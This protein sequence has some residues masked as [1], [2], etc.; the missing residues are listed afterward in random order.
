VNN[1][2][3]ED[4]CT[5]V[6]GSQP[7]KSEFCYE[8]KEGY[9]RLIQ[10]RDYKT[11]RFI[12]YIPTEKAKKFC[13][14]NDVMIGRYGPPVF[15]VLRGLKGAYNVALMKAVPKSNIENDYLYYL[16]KQDTIFKYVD[17]LSSRTGGQT[18]VDLDSLYKFPILLPNKDYQRKIVKLLKG[19]DDKIKNN[20]LLRSIFESMLRDIYLYW[21]VQFD[22]PDEN[23]NPYKTSGGKMIWNDELNK[24]I[25]EGWEYAPISK[26][27]KINTTSINPFATPNKQFKYYNIPDFDVVGTFVMEDGSNIKSNKYLVND[28]DILISKLNPWFNRII[29]VNEEEAI[30]S[31]EFIPLRTKSIKLKNYLYIISISEDFINYCSIN[32]TGTSNSHKRVDPEIMTDY[33]VCY[34][35]EIA[36]KFGELAN[37]LIEKIVYGIEENQRLAGFRDFLLPLLMNGQIKIR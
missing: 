11:N 33:K 24:E 1:A 25:P 27:C 10:T 22:F 15:Q 20:E 31:T 23:G 37:N 19:L 18:G 32:S 5:F 17:A 13:D 14:E 30:C 21:F 29:Y 35:E 2:L 3:I 28:N 7:A 16:L 9:I 36:D 6:G 34:N 26:F 8:Y 4:V 12:T